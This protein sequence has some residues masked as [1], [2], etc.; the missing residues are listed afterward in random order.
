MK[1]GVDKNIYS[2]YNFEGVYWADP[3]HQSYSLVSIRLADIAVE[4]ATKNT[5]YVKDKM[6]GAFEEVNSRSKALRKMT[7]EWS[8]L[9]T[10]KDGSTKELVR[11]DFDD[12]LKTDCP[13]V[14]S[15]IQIPLAGN[16][17]VYDNKKWLNTFVLDITKPD[18][19]NL[20]KCTELLAL[21]RESLCNQTDSKNLEEMLEELSD[22][23]AAKE[24]RFVMHWIAAIYQNP[25]VN[26]QTNLWFIGQQKGI[27]KGTFM[28]V[29]K[30]V[31][32]SGMGKA[33]QTEV[34]RGWNDN[35]VGKLLVEADEFKANDRLDY[36]SWLKRE[37]TNDVV[38]I[39]KRNT[40]S[41]DIPNLTNWM[42][43]TNDTNPVHIEDGDRRN[44]MIR[45]TDKLEWRDRAHEL[46]LVLN[47][48]LDMISGFCAILEI[49]E[50]N[51]D[52]IKTSFETE[53][54]LSVRANSQTAVEDW[55]ADDTVERGVWLKVKDHFLKYKG[56]QETYAC[57]SHIKSQ[58]AFAKAMREIAQRG[59]IKMRESGN[60]VFYRIN[61]L[62]KDRDHYNDSIVP[63]KPVEPRTLE[64]AKPSSIEQ[65]LNRI[66]RIRREH[67]EE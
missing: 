36:N 3:T 57:T 12:Y 48:S 22:K 64:P 14:F 9:H 35:I 54:R 17:I 31:F 49:L 61:D 11:R 37:T 32:G 28:R 26:L 15:D 60:C 21:I 8:G 53:M 39:T 56:W 7:N 43:T 47:D 33:V 16:H 18:A 24:F 62:E 46:N 4:S 66:D 5:F 34:G 6:S 13:T 10:L 27:G 38:S 42:F 44:V 67:D 58:R 30:R 29:L 20:D 1:S 45:T 25:G 2:E 65:D 40:S 59:E 52:L 23:K 55:L 50:I 41:V 63:F 19:K 51:W